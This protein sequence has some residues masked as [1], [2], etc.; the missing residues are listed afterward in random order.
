M[1]HLTYDEQRSIKAYSMNISSNYFVTPYSIMIMDKSSKAAK[2]SK[3]Q[4]MQSVP[5][6]PN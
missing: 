5:T 3:K 4:T 1:Y 6:P 2:Q